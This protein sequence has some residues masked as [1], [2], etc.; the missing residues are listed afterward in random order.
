MK[1]LVIK[2]LHKILRHLMNRGW[3]ENYLIVPLG[4]KWKVKYYKS[5]TH[6]IITNEL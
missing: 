2:T 5:T 1:K 3:I 4:V 6:L